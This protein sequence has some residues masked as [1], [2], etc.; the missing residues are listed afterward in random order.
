[1]GAISGFMGASYV[2]LHKYF[3]LCRPELARYHN[4]FWNNPYVLAGIVTSTYVLLAFF[5]GEFAFQ[6]SRMAISDL[7][8]A[9]SLKEC[10][11]PV[12]DC[13]FTDWGQG[14][15]VYWNL[16]CFSVL[17]YIFS[18][19]FLVLDWPC[20]CFA[21]VFAIGAATGRLMGE[22]LNET[23]MDWSNTKLLAATYA[24]V[25]AA[26]LV[27]GVTRTFSVAVIVIEMT[28]S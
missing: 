16:F 1:M 2:Q 11:D 6:P 19:W 7:F 12:N 9:Q 8:N 20:G 25:G 28:L 24:V 23:V 27:G 15:G 17:N 21:S 26:S 14:L 5:L 22:I 18:I 13:N 3:T 10:S 4:G